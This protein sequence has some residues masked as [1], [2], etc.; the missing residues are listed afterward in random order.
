MYIKKIS[1]VNYK[2]YEQLE[3]KLSEKI[4]C[5]FGNNGVGKTNLLD[6]VYYL[7][8][9]KS[10]F[11][12]T[13]SHNIKHKQNFFVIQGEYL[14]NEAIEKIYCGVKR[15]QKKVFRRN[16]K[17]YKKLS[18]HIGL[19]P[20][21]MI[22]PADG[23]LIS[24]GSE[25]R[26]KYIDGVISQ[27]DKE[28]LQILIKYNR[29]LQQRNALL[30]EFAKKH[31]FDYDML[32]VWTEQMSLLGTKIH[33]KRQDFI[34]KLIPVFRYYY[35]YISGGNEEIALKYK[36]HI[37]DNDMSE[38]MRQNIEKDRIMQY[39][40]IGTHKDE[41][42]FELKNYPIKK[43]GSQGQQKTY[44]ISLKLAQFE[45]MREVSNIKPLLLLDDIFDKLDGK[46]LI[47]ILEL[48]S[49]P[50][51]GQI[52]ITDTNINRLDKILKNKEMPHKLFEVKKEGLIKE[53]F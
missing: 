20:I 25:E 17:E 11:N 47:K 24:G 23:I 45:F 3:I 30:K 5:I 44:L 9:C 40:S 48:V 4:N 52:F 39:T 51:F 42:N 8:M 22:S 41:L 35:K 6:I 43:I 53:V 38:L 29:A 27:Y 14:I 37:T 50:K 13:D 33:K 7:S 2:N 32:F 1:A 21:V 34:D 46:R 36:S 26:R 28:Y 49:S 19:L 31:F 18:K 10:Y 12:T 16:G 15:G